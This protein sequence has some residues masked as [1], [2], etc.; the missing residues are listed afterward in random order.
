MR[1]ALGG[2]MYIGA[3]DYR[4]ERQYGLHDRGMRLSIHGL[5][6]LKAVLLAQIRQLRIGAFA[7]LVSMGTAH[8]RGLAMRRHRCCARIRSHRQLQEQQRAKTQPRDEDSPRPLHKVMLSQAN[9][10]SFEDPDRPEPLI[11]GGQWQ[12][13]SK[14][15]PHR[16]EPGTTV[17]V[18]RG[19]GSGSAVNHG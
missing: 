7:R 4:D 5:R 15:V 8:R 17:R 1:I 9:A 12:R 10:A 16:P 19:H 11:F 13:R 6:R 2:K 3:N 14:W 18:R